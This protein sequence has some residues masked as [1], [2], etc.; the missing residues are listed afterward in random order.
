MPMLIDPFKDV[1]LIFFYFHVAL[2]VEP[3]TFTILMHGNKEPFGLTSHVIYIIWYQ[4]MVTQVT[5]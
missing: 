4:E 1:V 2:K 3:L 5:V